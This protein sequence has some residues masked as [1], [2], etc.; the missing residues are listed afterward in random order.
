MIRIKDQM[1]QIQ[2]V[3]VGDKV[4]KDS[5]QVDELLLSLYKRHFEGR[6]IPQSQ[7]I[8]EKTF[9]RKDMINAILESNFH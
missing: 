8:W 9:T 7:N 6:A 5:T 2:R 3:I 1:L 4:Y